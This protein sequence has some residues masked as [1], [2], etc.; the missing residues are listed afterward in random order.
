MTKLDYQQQRNFRG[1]LKVA[2]ISI[3]MIYVYRILIF[4]S[5]LT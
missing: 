1:K 2:I 4:K 5:D 3:K